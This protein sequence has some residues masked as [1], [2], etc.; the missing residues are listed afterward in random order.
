MD[1]ATERDFKT[2]VAQS[3]PALFRVAFALTGQQH[4]AEDLLQVALERVYVRWHRL[5]DPAGYT[6]RVMYHEYVSWWRKWR[7]REVPMAVLPELSDVDSAAQVLLRRALHAALGGL[8]PRQRAV[9]VLR[10]LEDLSEQ[11]VAEL[12]G[13]SVKTVSSQSSRALAQLRSACGWLM[14]TKA[15]EVAE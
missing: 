12:L 3:T 2:F 5:T 8:P 13:C 9:L 11:Q 10:Y 7:R 4:A 6:K 15:K 1:S 14:E